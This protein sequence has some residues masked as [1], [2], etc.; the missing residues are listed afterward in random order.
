MKQLVITCILALSAV[1]AHAAGEANCRKIEYAELR[2]TP[3][4][5]LLATY[6]EYAMARKIGSD[7]YISGLKN[8]YRSDSLAEASDNCFDQLTNIARVLKLR[9][10]AVPE[11][12]TTDNAD[13]PKSCIKK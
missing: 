5:E 13:V 4:K 6:C 8:G 11:G 9:K 2:D 3:T 1:S 10:V 7:A 12:I